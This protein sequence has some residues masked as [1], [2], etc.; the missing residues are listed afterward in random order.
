M[1]RKK[2]VEAPDEKVMEILNEIHGLNVDDHPE[3]EEKKAKLKA[4][5]EK[6]TE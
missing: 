3:L 2:K 6:L 4:K 1:G 5:L